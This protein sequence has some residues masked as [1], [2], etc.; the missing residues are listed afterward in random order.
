MQRVMG[1]GICALMQE[2]KV[3]SRQEQKEILELDFKT[4]TKYF[5]LC[6]FPRL[7]PLNFLFAGS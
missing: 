2:A 4:A 3:K 5:V 7:I 1:A 6:H